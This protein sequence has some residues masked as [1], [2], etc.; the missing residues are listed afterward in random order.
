MTN[1]KVED[2]VIEAYRQLVNYERGF[3]SPGKLSNRHL[4]LPDAQAIRVRTGSAYE[5]PFA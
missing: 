3:R 2:G 4:G 1:E 5:H